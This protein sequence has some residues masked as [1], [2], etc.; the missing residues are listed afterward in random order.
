L[1]WGSATTKFGLLIISTATGKTKL[2]WKIVNNVIQFG[3]RGQLRK[4]L[5]LAVG[6]PFIAHHIMP[7]ALQTKTVI[8]RA[9]KYANPFHMNSPLN[10]IALSN[11]VHTGNHQA[12]SDLIADKLDDFIAS[13]PNATPQECYNFLTNL[14]QR[15]RLW[16]TNNPTTN[17]NQIILP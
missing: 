6:N 13:N 4:V 9:A 11:V 17:I 2:V 1:G 5:N 16:I 3:D 15:I 8:Q 10:G 12:Y 7:W 14:I